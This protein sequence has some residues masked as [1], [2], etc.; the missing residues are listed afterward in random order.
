MGIFQWEQNPWGQETLIRIS[1]DLFW[2]SMAVGAVFIIGHLIYRA[3]NPPAKAEGA[4]TDASAAGIPDKVVRHSVS[5]RLFH[6][7]MTV[8][9]FVLLVTGFFPVLGIQFN[10]LAIHWIA[11][12]AFIATIVFHIV[13]A[14]FWMKLRNMWIDGK[15]WSEWKQEMRRVMGKGGPLPPKSAKIPSGSAPVPRHDHPRRLRRHVDRA[16]YAGTCRHPALRSQ[17]LSLCR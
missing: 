3:K 11:G 1:W 12:I 6:W 5:S 9:V 13:H 10:W 14:T 8:V 16:G 15:D 4:V 7:V 17:S 2:L